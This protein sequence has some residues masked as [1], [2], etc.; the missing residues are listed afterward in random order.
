[1]NFSKILIR[2]L[3]ITGL[4]TSLAQA[5]C[6]GPYCNKPRVSFGVSM[7]A[8]IV[9]SRPCYAYRP[10]VP[11]APVYYAPCAPCR[12]HMSIGFGAGPMGIGF[13]F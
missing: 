9:Y 11:C 8:P 13:S 12:P 4:F 7:G 5:R 2:A 3:V 6:H 10:C 1:M